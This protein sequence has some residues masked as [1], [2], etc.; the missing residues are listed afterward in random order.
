MLQNYTKHLIF[1]E[2]IKT[3]F[4]VFSTFSLYFSSIFTWFFEFFHTFFTV[5]YYKLFYYIIYYRN[6]NIWKYLVSSKMFIKWQKLAFFLKIS[7]KPCVFFCIFKKLKYI[8]FVNF[9][10]F[11]KYIFICKFN[12]SHLIT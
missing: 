9:L 4:S 3:Q 6:K 8:N 1:S 10:M 7:K 5:F 2:N 12:N 11:K